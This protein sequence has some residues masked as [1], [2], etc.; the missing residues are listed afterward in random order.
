MN[1]HFFLPSLLI[2]SNL[3]INF[4]VGQG[5]TGIWWMTYI[6]IGWVQE[7]SMWKR[8]RSVKGIDWP[9]NPITTMW[10]GLWV[11][12]ATAQN[13]R[14]VR[15]WGLMGTRVDYRTY[16]WQTRQT[17]WF[18]TFMNEIS[19]KDT[20]E[21]ETKNNADLLLAAGNDGVAARGWWWCSSRSSVGSI[22]SRRSSSRSVSGTRPRKN[23]PG[24]FT[25]NTKL[26]CGDRRVREKLRSCW[27]KA[28]SA[29]CWVT[30]WALGWAAVGSWIVTRKKWWVSCLELRLQL[31]AWPGLRTFTRTRSK[32]LIFPGQG[33]QFFLQ[34]ENEQIT[35]PVAKTATVVYISESSCYL[36][37]T[38]LVQWPM[39]HLGLWT[40]I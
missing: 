4:T 15:K 16:Y 5:E 31:L 27:L 32:R 29:G 40:H 36:Q 6:V 20:R 13:V 21:Q 37:T 23:F 18:Y 1:L 7:R 28:R 34:E 25:L 24:S 2:S 19:K 9:I 33:L 14:S 38:I 22:L 26:L 8:L 17:T 30:V 10:R 12:E 39:L 35:L 11:A 3:K